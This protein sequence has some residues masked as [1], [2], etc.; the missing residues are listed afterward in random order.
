[1]YSLTNESIRRL[2]PAGKWAGQGREGS[3]GPPGTTAFASTKRHQPTNQ[4]AC[5]AFHLVCTH[6]KQAGHSIPN[7][8]NCGDIDGLHLAVRGVM[9]AVWTGF[10]NWGVH[11]MG[12]HTKPYIYTH[13]HI[14][15]AT[16]CG[17]KMASRRL[18]GFGSLLTVG[19]VPAGTLLSCTTRERSVSQS[20]SKQV[21]MQKAI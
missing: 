17:T 19:Y 1:M 20:V 14:T 18:W 4:P 12:R 7:C 8:Q 10:D 2:W 5:P 11:H 3:A 6:S 16:Q 9:D 13:T 15:P 21:L